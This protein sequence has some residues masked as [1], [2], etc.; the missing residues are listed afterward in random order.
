MFRCSNQLFN[1][2][3]II[4]LPFKPSSALPNSRS[5]RLLCG[6]S[7][8]LRNNLCTPSAQT[9][10]RRITKGAQQNILRYAPF[11]LPFWR[12]FGACGA[13]LLFRPKSY[14]L[15]NYAITT[16]N[17]PLFSGSYPEFLKFFL[18]FLPC[19][20]IVTVPYHCILDMELFSF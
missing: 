8:L 1:L 4:K 10:R 15:T 11:V 3:E 7:R 14:Y 5:W 12:R 6:G 13:A 18:L 16:P 2:Q 20:T 17:Y 9:L 19:I